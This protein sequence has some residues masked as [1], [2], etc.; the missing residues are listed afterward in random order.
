MGLLNGASELA[1]LGPMLLFG[2][3]VDRMRRRP[4]MIG[5]DLGRAGLIALVPVLAWTGTLAMP[6]S[7]SWP[8]WWAA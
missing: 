4:L 6:C 2:V 7:T 5:T 3:L 1:F 8:S